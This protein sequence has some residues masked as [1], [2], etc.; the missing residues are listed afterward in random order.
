[1]DRTIDILVVNSALIIF[2]ILGLLGLI[3]AIFLGA[4]HIPRS[5][6]NLDTKEG[7]Y[8]LELLSFT[9]IGFIVF[10]IGL[11]YNYILITIAGLAM[12]GPALAIIFG[13]MW[14]FLGIVL[15]SAGRFVKYVLL[16]VKRE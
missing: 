2:A 1:M 6:R 7:D 9:I 5:I 11:K 3:D 4:A 10:A 8:T 13:F 14:L 16:G 12:T 15:C